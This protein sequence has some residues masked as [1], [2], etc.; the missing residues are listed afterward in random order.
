MLAHQAKDR[1]ISTRRSRQDDIYLAKSYGFGTD[2]ASIIMSLN[3]N[4][5]F[6]KEATLESVIYA[7]NGNIQFDKAATIT[8]SV[9]AGGSITTDKDQAFT[10]LPGATDFFALP[11][12]SSG[13]LKTLTWDIE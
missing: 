10:Y 8:G 3:G 13:P 4:I 1:G 6:K 12:Y 7:P 11:G 2:G 9:V 5:T